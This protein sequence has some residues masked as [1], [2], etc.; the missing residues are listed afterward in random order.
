MKHFFIV[1]NRQKDEELVLTR[2]V[3]SYLI[4]HGA[5][6]MVQDEAQMEMEC[7]D[8]AMIPEDTQGMLVLGG[9]G[10]LI[11]AAR[12]VVERELPLIGVNLGT[13]GYL[14]EVEEQN[15]FSSL[16][17]LLEDRFEIEQRMM[18]EGCMYCGSHPNDGDGRKDTRALALN[19]IV[20]CRRGPLRI[21][22]FR[23]FVNGEQLYTYG[24]D[25]M[26]ISTPTGS[27][28]YSLSA[29]GPIVSPKAE[30]ILITPICPHTLNTRSVVVSSE[31]EVT[32]EIGP[33]RRTQTEYC[34]LS[35]DGTA[36]VPVATGDRVVV[37]RAK[38]KTKIMRI[39]K[40][41]FME[42]LR[43]KMNEG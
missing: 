9:D 1:T 6:C 36:A 5:T 30:L 11:Q 8:P 24:A 29:G 13:L 2:Q 41:S 3:Q 10:T 33:G 28:G 42:T 14:A 16:D 20:I 39:H 25:G 34:E 23:I 32:I 21:L 17:A 22:E 15:L 37:R 18:L 43:N 31:D 35:F 38:K 7:T 19:D 12:D 26:I 40:E 4:A 27:T